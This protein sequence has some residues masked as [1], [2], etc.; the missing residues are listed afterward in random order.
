LFRVPAEPKLRGWTPTGKSP[1]SLRD[2]L[3][4]QKTG[5]R[6]L[7]FIVFLLFF[8]FNLGTSQDHWFAFRYDYDVLTGRPL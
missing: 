6:R 3:S 8:A 4:G 5:G 7:K 2:N 1:E